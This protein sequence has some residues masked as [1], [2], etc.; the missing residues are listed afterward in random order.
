LD[1]GL[2]VAFAL[3][4]WWFST[5]AV[6]YLIGLPRHTYGLSMLAAT[7][8][9]GMAL[10][11]LW[12]LRDEESVTGAYLAFAA[13]LIVWAWH[14]M[15]FLTGLVTGSRT[16]ASPQPAEGWRRFVYATQALIY[17]ELAIL[18]TAGAVVALTWD[19]PNQ[20]G[21]WTF[22]ILWIARLSA[23]LNV[24]LGVPNLTE[25]FLPSHLEYM[26]TYFRCRRMNLLFPLSVTLST[27]L[28]GLL[29]QGAIA[30]TATPYEVVGLTLLSALMALVVV[31]HWFLVLPL[32][33]AALW[34]WGMQSRER[35][36]EQISTNASQKEE[37]ARNPQ[38]D[39]CARPL[40]G[41]V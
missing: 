34:S 36:N 11:G 38:F 39:S 5:G 7:A 26:K 30:D 4:A 15:S 23:K 20:I 28:T 3:F 33:A 40:A 21:A 14:E 17:H 19:A 35:G 1:H 9:A 2:A 37:P 27:V 32:P 6:L 29:I 24:F 12:L 8:A 25:E 41:N 18:A 10:L 13:G 31:E 22:L 16:T